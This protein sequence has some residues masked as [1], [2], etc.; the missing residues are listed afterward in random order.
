MVHFEILVQGLVQ[1][2][3]YALVAVGLTLVY[4]LLRIL[5]I[6]HAG[7]FSLGGYIALLLANQTGSFAFGL[8]CSV[9]LV[10]LA[11]MAIYRL[12]YQPI[13]D[14]PPYVAL[15]VS[16]GL[17]II[18]EEV[19]RLVFGPSTIS[20]INPPLQGIVEFYGIRLREVEIATMAVAILFIGGV[21]I[22]ST[23]TR[24]GVAWRATVDDPEMARSFGVRLYSVRYFNFFMASVMAA[25]A[26]AMVAVSNNM[27]EPTMGGV[28]AYKALAIIVMG[29]LGDVRGTL[30]A[31]LALGIIESFGTIYLGSILDRDAIAFAF[32]IIVLMFRPQGLLVR[33]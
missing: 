6:A 9:L 17:Y 29:G 13:L 33:N 23:K 28:P 30:F 7:L 12:A 4:G 16:I 20:F 8:A 18:M 3:I 19:F 1:G 25:T 21:G 31:A 26:G 27:V 10:G 32:L 2:T 22:L 5:H 15:I 14:K 24:I 11:G